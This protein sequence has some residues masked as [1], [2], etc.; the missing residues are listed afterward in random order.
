MLLRAVTLPDGSVADVRIKGALIAE[1]AP[2]ITAMPGEPVE[3]LAGHLLLPAFVEPHAHLDKALTADIVPNPT[4]DLPGAIDAWTAHKATLSALDIAQRARRAA[5]MLVANGTT[6]IRTHVDVTTDIGL[7]ALEALLAVRHDLADLVDLQLVALV[8]SPLT[9]NAGAEQRALLR[10]ALDAGADV[11]GGCPHLDDDPDGATDLVLDAAA[12]AGVPVDL[13]A[14]ETL[15]P[16][17]LAV[18]HLAHVV[19]SGFAH[20]VTASHCVSLGVQPVEVQAAV[21]E[22]IA[23]AGIAVVTL[24]QTN[25]FLQAR[26][27][28]VAAPRG[29]TALRAL[30]DAGAVVAGGGD[31]LQD[32]FNPMGRGDPLEIASLLVT[33]GHLLP[34]EALWAVSGAGRLALGLPA[35]TI[36]AGAPAELV[37]LASSGV[38]HAMG[39]A[40]GDRLVIHRGRVVC[41]SGRVPRP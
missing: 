36:T 31:N 8:G 20:P 14:D 25:L 6:A 3:L 34:A 29:L 12:S 13:H 21:A 38:R 10:A 2:A 40:P 5:I 4:G 15:D 35:V 19:A 1:V 32:P 41:R 22:A 24:P 17:K 33:A 9:G 7:L 30:L 18:A 26:D 23:A 27:R 39:T 37:A 28:P 11:A 16:T